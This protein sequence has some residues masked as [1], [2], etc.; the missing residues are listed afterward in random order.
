MFLTFTV[1]VISISYFFNFVFFLFFFSVLFFFFFSSRRRHTRSL[2]DWSSDV[3]SSDL[4]FPLAQHELVVGS[5]ARDRRQDAKAG[6][7]EIKVEIA[8]R[9]DQR[10]G[11]PDLLRRLAQRGI[12]GGAVLR[13]DLAAG[14]RDLSGMTRKLGAQRKQDRRLAAVDDRDEHRGRPRRLH[15]YLLPHRGIEIEI[16]A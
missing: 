5:N 16:A 14:K 3:C 9:L 6:E 8:D 7:G 10:R 11:E 4:D 12:G 13:F 15:P 1:S 2:C